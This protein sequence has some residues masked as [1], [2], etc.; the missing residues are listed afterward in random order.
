M[1]KIIAMS[2]K[3]DANSPIQ[4]LNYI[5]HPLIEIGFIL[6]YENHESIKS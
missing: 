5:L 1:P 4:N 2:I 6:W 3:I